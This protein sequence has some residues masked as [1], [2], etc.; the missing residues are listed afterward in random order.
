MGQLQ[1]LPIPTIGALFLGGRGGWTHG[2]AL[3][4]HGRP[5]S[6]DVDFAGLSATCAAFMRLDPN[7]PAP[8]ATDLDRG[9]VALLA[10]Q[11]PQAL[12]IAQ[13]AFAAA[14]R[15]AAALRAV[16]AMALRALARAAMGDLD[17]A[18][19]D[20]RGSARMAQSEGLPLG[21]ALAGLVLARLR[22]LTGRPHLC[23]RILAATQAVAP[24]D[25][26]AWVAFERLLCG[27]PAGKP[28]LPD[29]RQDPPALA[30]LVALDGDCRQGRR[31][32][33]AASLGRLAQA[34]SPW[35]PLADDVLA[36]AALIDPD[37]AAPLDIQAFR[38]GQHHSITR[39]LH[40]FGTGA[41][42][43]A[44]DEAWAFVHACQGR[45]GVRILRG[46]IP[47]WPAESLPIRS[48]DDSSG[49]RVGTA[50]CVLALAGPAGLA[51]A[52]F[53]QIV[54][55]FAFDLGRH[56]GV[57]ESL[58]HRARRR[59]GDAGDLI[60]ADAHVALHLNRDIN[61]PDPRC[62]LPVPDRLLRSLV[63]LGS[64]GA[65]DAAR[66]L[67]L[68]LRT[69]QAALAQLVEEGAVLPIRNGRQVTYQVVDTTFT[70]LSGLVIVRD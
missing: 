12:D 55:G 66:I 10:G 49:D 65:A 36:L 60:R 25:L 26:A 1:D 57:L 34:V 33:V 32:A 68:P 18:L 20:A 8:P 13:A 17:L 31:P 39:G 9:F 15:E 62:A 14:V 16:E 54:Y 70:S 59:L 19:A 37:L 30:A 40:G 43:A 11:G 61:L 24:S 52:D 22:R 4:C 58:F 46:A 27:D 23:T 53:F 48:G 41:S 56:H 5:V 38:S 28:P 29:L 50:L 21:I 44:D 45:P 3:L 2:R 69:I 7:L 6:E 42:G 64:P 51:R 47:L 63:D 35:Q 67:G